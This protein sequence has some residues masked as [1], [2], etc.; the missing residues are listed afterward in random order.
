MAQLDLKNYLIAGTGT[1]KGGTKQELF[2]S[3]VLKVSLRCLQK[4]IKLFS[5]V[6]FLGFVIN[7]YF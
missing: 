2:E 7:F 6:C 3:T 1:K 5:V 4:E